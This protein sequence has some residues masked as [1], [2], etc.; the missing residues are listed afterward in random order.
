M[1][2]HYKPLTQEMM[3]M[4]NQAPSIVFQYDLSAIKVRLQLY[5]TILMRVPNNTLLNSACD[6]T[7]KR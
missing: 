3:M 6:L 1:T 4:L 2:E 5:H 7:T